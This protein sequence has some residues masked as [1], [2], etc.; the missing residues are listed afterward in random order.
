MFEASVVFQPI[1]VQGIANRYFGG[2]HHFAV[3]SGPGTVWLQSLALS[4]LAASLAPYSGAGTGRGTAAE[5][6]DIS[7]VNSDSR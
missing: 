2:A 3:L 6:S 4:I 7:A 5:G 1:Q